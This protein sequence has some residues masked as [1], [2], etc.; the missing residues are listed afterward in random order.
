MVCAKLRPVA[1]ADE[2]GLSVG[3]FQND[4]NIIS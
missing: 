4:E 2:K 3:N 1:R